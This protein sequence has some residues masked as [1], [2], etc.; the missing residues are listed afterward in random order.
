MRTKAW[1]RGRFVGGVAALVV[2]VGVVVGCGGGGHGG[3]DLGVGDDLATAGGELGGDA[4]LATTATHDLASASDDLAMAAA[5]LATAPPDLTPP[6]DLAITTCRRPPA[7]ADRVRYVVV[8]HPFDAAGNKDTRLEVLALSK[9]GALSKTAKTFD[10]GNYFDGRIVFTPDG[11]L[12]FQPQDDGSVGE[13]RL[14]ADGTPTV[15]QAA[16]RGSFFASTVVMDPSGERLYVLDSDT[17]DN[18]GGIISLR[19]GCDGALGEEGNIAP[20]QLPYQLLFMPGDPTRAVVFAGG[21]LDSTGTADDYLLAWS[22]TAP[23]VL[24]QAYAFGNGDAITSSAT[25]TPDGKLALFADHANSSA[26][27]GD[28]AVVRIEGNTMT[29]LQLMTNLPGNA[30]VVVSPFSNAGLVLLSDTYDAIIALAYAPGN[31]TAPF[32]V[33]GPIAYKGARP[34]LPGVGILIDRGALRGRVLISEVDGVRQVHF[35]ANGTITDDGLFLV[36]GD[37]A[38]SVGALGVQP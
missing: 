26:T 2:V 11:E 15:L 7:P 28:V 33:T 35:N 4:D 23:K 8:T 32:T 31:A 17:R 3:H 1:V 24:G 34:Q 12:G 21:I 19:I 36:G 20:A 18:G 22:P 25:L 13:F 38:G 9:T 37:L 6:A 10:M 14:D 29:P 30:D 27:T 5:D 16:F